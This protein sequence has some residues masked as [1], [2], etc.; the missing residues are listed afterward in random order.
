MDAAV[1]DRDIGLLPRAHDRTS[2]PSLCET[3]VKT[4]R[5]DATVE[6]LAMLT[7]GETGP[8]DTGPWMRPTG[9]RHR[10]AY[11][12]IKP[13]VL[14]GRCPAS[15]FARPGSCIAMTASASI[16]YASDYTDQL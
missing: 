10:C 7:A 13:R 11:N 12:G 5:K 14:V 15:G 6:H 1:A 8:G 2:R 4:F 9:G 3:A 16:E